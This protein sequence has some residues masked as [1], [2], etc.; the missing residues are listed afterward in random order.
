[1][2]DKKELY[3]TLIGARV[4]YYRKIS[5]VKQEELA[6]RVDLSLS[7]LQR[8]EQGTYNK[9]ISLTTLL[10]IADGLR[11]DVQLLLNISTD[12]KRLMGWN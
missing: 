6:R 9:S 12:E 7:A 5:G 11:I 4:R 8:I 3:L 1:M 10:D 2:S